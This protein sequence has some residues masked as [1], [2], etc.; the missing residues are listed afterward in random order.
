MAS[1]PSKLATASYNK[2]FSCV[3]SPQ[4]CMWR[5]DCAAS[6]ILAWLTLS[7]TDSDFDGTGPMTTLR[8]VPFTVATVGQWGR[9]T[10][11]AASLLAHQTQHCF[12]LD[13]N[14][15]KLKGVQ[16]I[17]DVGGTDVRASWALVGQQ[18]V[19][20]KASVRALARAPHSRSLPLGRSSPSS[21]LS[22]LTAL[23]RRTAAW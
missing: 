20:V 23:R 19:G 2:E 1:A 5:C 10:L 3:E 9:G 13:R 6:S 8:C 14:C 21:D 7:A 18:S 4:N 17:L 11:T 12:P 22:I 16:G 15:V